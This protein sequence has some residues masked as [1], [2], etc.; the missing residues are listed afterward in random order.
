MKFQ[1]FKMTNL[2]CKTQEPYNKDKNKEK[3]WRD[4]FID[5]DFRLNFKQNKVNI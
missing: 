3:K 2:I 4:N 5:K 1:D